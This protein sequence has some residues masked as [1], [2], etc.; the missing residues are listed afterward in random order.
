MA[1]IKYCS[2]ATGDDSTGDGSYGNPYKTIDKASTGLTGG[3]EVRVAKSP[4]NTA[5]TG[6]ITF[7][8]GSTGITGSGTLFTTELAVGDYIQGGDSNWYEV[9]TITDNTTAALYKVYSSTTQSGVS[10]YKL[11]VTSTGA[12]AALTTAVQSVSASGS[13]ASKLLISGGWD[14]S[15]Q[16]QTGQTYFRQM[17]GTF[18]NRYGEDYILTRKIIYQFQ[19]FIF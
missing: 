2:F 18:A 8:L 5:L 9:V 3:D 4:A 16:T 1:T 15:T 7:T 11:G 14:L 12:A 19:G 17:N 10:S 13:T 6:T